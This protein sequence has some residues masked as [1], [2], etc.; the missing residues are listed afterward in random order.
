MLNGGADADLFII[1][2]LPGAGDHDVFQDF[3]SGVDR[4]GLAGS[5][6]GFYGIETN[7]SGQA[8]TLNGTVVFES[9]VGRLWWDTDGA[10]AGRTLLG[11]FLNGGVVTSGDIIL[12]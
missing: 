6:F 8:A 9:D 4:L 7:T 12:V 5:V 10:G 1:A 3:V 11:Q 2:A